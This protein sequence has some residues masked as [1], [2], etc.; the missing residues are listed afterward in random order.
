MFINRYYTNIMIFIDS[1]Q[2]KCF[3]NKFSTFVNVFKFLI[4]ML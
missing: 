4:F 3:E 1:L 2:N